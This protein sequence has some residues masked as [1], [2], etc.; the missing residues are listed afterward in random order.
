VA[1]GLIVHDEPYSILSDPAPRTSV[2]VRTCFRHSLA[3]PRSASLAR[4]RLQGIEKPT[5]STWGAGAPSYG[6]NPSKPSEPS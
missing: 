1:R 2:I 6:V 4:C 3:N 5:D